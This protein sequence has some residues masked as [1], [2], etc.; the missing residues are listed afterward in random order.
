MIKLLT[1]A[2]QEAPESIELAQLRARRGELEGV[3]SI[4][5]R[6]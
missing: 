1:A 6:T 4:D 3:T 5:K 2:L